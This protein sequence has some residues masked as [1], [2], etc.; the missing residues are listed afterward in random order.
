LKS[1]RVIYSASLQFDKDDF[2][3]IPFE[4]LIQLTSQSYQM[5]QEISSY[6]G[7]YFQ[8]YPDFVQFIQYLTFF[9]KNFDPLL[10]GSDFFNSFLMVFQK[11]PFE[12]YSFLS[13][14][15]HYELFIQSIYPNPPKDFPDFSHTL[16]LYS[17]NFLVLSIQLVPDSIH[18]IFNNLNFHH[19]FSNCIN[20]IDSI[21]I[22]SIHLLLLI[23]KS[24]TELEIDLSIA[25]S[26]IQ[27]IPFLLIRSKFREKIFLFEFLL[28]VSSFQFLEYIDESFFDP[29]LD[30]LFSDDT[31]LITSSLSL[32][33]EIIR[34]H[35]KPIPQDLYDM[36]LS[37]DVNSSL[38]L[39]KIILSEVCI[40]L[41][42]I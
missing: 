35:Q 25:N 19:L 10:F 1:Y 36:I 11:S 40:Q 38:M 29:I 32:L 9:L 12:F 33:L 28:L 30:S 41:D 2:K 5:V 4:I 39:P 13:K 23:L 37:L 15:H 8:K 27:R 24:N 6:I 7:V 17:T 21:G 14:N 34:K 22:S 26:L 16:K 18:I 42:H 20:G 3:N 31:E